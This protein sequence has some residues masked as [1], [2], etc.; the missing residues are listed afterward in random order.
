MIVIKIILGVFIL[1]VILYGIFA[2]TRN[3]VLAIKARNKKWIINGSILLILCFLIL[4]FIV[5]P[6]YK[7][8]LSDLQE[9]LKK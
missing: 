8:G 5:L 3:I 1:G 6:D 4:L 2:M 9:L 7:E